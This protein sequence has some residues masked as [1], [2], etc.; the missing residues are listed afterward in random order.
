MIEILQ[1]FFHLLIFFLFTYFPF[2]K[3]TFLRFSFVSTNSNYNAFFI[4][5]IFI[6]NIFLFFSFLRINLNL[7]FIIIFLTYLILFLLSFKEII[8]EIFYKKNVSLKWALIFICCCLFFKTAANIELGWDAL[9][10]WLSK[11]NN[12]Y[13]NKSSFDM[14]HPSSP[15]LGSYIWAFFWKNSF[16]NKEYLG[17]LFFDYLYLISIFIVAVSLKSKSDFKKLIFIFFLILLSFDYNNTLAGYQD[18]LLFALLIFCSK[19]L[20]KLNSR[21]SFS[22]N[23]IYSLL[24][25]MTANLLPWVKN[26]GIFYAFFIGI[27]YLFT[28]PQLLIT[29]FIFTG[30]ILINIIR[31]LFVK[32]ILE[33]GQIFQDPVTSEVLFKNI[34]DVRELIFR[35]C[36]I[37]FY[38]VRSMFYY[39]IILITF[40]CLIFFFKYIKYLHD[41]KI[42]YIFFFFNLFFIYTIY[43]TTTSPFVWQ[44]QTSMNRLLLQTSGFYLFLLVDLL[45]Q[46]KI[47]RFD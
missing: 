13:D 3:F 1:I 5:I 38:L 42:Y 23:L 16:I 34:I 7:I 28:S 25:V 40:I 18:Y 10:Y 29:K 43:I 24:L 26:E 46:K 12:F 45:N 4:N 2:N 44:M 15:Q 6:L 21:L 22:E 35:I 37:S 41:K 32:F 8:R 30:I 27:I 36:Y 11:V 33:S 9:S 39:P 31:I 20:L 19:V 47:F 14:P 17:R